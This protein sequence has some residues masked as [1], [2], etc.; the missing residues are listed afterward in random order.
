MSENSNNKARDHFLLKP[1]RPSYVT[2]LSVVR[3]AACKLPSGKGTRNDI[4][5]LLKESQFVN[6]EI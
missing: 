3:D 4:C 5:T 6:D 2:L 1:S